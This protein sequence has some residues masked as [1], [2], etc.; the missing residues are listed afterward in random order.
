MKSLYL[1]IYLTTVVVLLLFASLSGWMFQRQIEQERGRAQSMLSERMGAW[2]ELIQRSL[3]GPEASVDSQA[4]EL[5]E[6]SQRLRLPLALDSAS[7]ERIAASESF[8]RRQA[9]GAPGVAIKL[10]DGRTLW[11]M[12]PGRGGGGPGGRRGDASAAGDPG[13]G[14]P[15]LPF[16][17]PAWQRGIGL[18]VVLVILF[19]AVAAGAYPVVRRLT[20]RLEALKRGVEQFGEGQLAHRVAI[21]GHDEVAA[22]AASFNVAA[23]RVETLVRSHQSLLAN[24]SHELRS[25]LARMKMAVSMLDG[26]SPDQRERLKRE[27][28]TNVAELDALVE[29]VLLAS[30]LDAKSSALHAEAIDL[31]ALAV[32]EAARVQAAVEGGPASVIGDERLVR[33][34]LRNLLENARR[35]GGSDISVSIDRPSPDGGV[36]LRVCDRGTGVPEAMRERIFEPFFRLPGH[37]EQA[38]G[39]GLGLSLVK[40]IAERHGGRVR[41]EGRDGGGSC[42]VIDLPPRPPA[43]A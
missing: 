11:V 4:S 10:E 22:V 39:V 8:L 29:E 28:D 30:R 23:E 12:R 16:L 17:P 38:G 24:A 3:P 21:S 5:R 34:A 36:T 9:D 18:I 43:A 13:G 40:Q 37:A 7:G 41:C 14:P 42:F 20:R 27:I 15:P 35:Y 33:R 31:L 32:E 25:P 19:I 26:A 6:W 2:A 1:R